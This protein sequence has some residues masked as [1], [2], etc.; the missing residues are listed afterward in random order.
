MQPRPFADAGL[1]ALLRKVVETLFG[2]TVRINDRVLKQVS[3]RILGCQ[4][5]CRAAALVK[6]GVDAGLGAADAP[7]VGVGL[8]E[9]RD[10]DGGVDGGV[11]EHVEVVG[12]GA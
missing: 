12:R 11:A 10:A 6:V 2:K 7:L 1:C 5:A 8:E 4:R 3:G 9:R